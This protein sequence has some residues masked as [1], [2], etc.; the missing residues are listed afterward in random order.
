MSDITLH[1]CLS[2]S[3]P[4]HITQTYDDAKTFIPADSN[5]PQGGLLVLKQSQLNADVYVSKR[6]RRWEE[7]LFLY[8]VLWSALIRV[9]NQNSQDVVRWYGTTATV[10]LFA[11]QLSSTGGART[12]YNT[13][14]EKVLR[15]SFKS[16]EVTLGGV[17]L[18]LLDLTS[19]STSISTTSLSLISRMSEDV[20]RSSRQRPRNNKC[21]MILL[22]PLSVQI[23]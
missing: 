12:S 13:A 9:I 18:I 1:F 6:V 8:L 15:C 16:K 21:L 11:R 3:R 7:R 20:R 10:P 4:A 5:G 23:F 19:V 22:S 17:I 2:T 14:K